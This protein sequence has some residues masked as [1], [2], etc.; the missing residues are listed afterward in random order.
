MAKA[1]ATK[2]HRLFS[3]PNQKRAQP[4]KPKERFIQMCQFC[5]A[6]MAVADGQIAKFHAECR[7]KVR[8]LRN[9]GKAR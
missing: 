6:P 3:S 2:V 1:T 7:K 8:G 5:D 9:Q 4:I